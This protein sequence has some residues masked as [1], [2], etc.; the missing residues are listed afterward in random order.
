MKSLTWCLFLASWFMLSGNATRLAAA[1]DNSPGPDERLQRLERRINELT[2]RQE[3][4][5]RR[6]AGQ[7]EAR[8]Q[9]AR[10]FGAAPGPQGRMVPPGPEGFQG[11]MS[12]DGPPA[13]MA[14]RALHGL[15]DLMRLIILVWIVCNILLAI[16]ISTD[17]RKRGE[18]SGLFIA[19]A[20]LAGIP[21]AIIYSLVRIGDRVPITGK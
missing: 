8:G 4:M 15:G 10:R 9:M 21:A 12:P 20:L 2:E 19:M 7:H 11:P 13:P 18:G 5:M 14:A 6:F 3:Q 17:I 16:W 1:E